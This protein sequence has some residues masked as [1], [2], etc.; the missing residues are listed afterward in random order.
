M[1]RSRAVPV[2]EELSQTVTRDEPQASQN[3]QCVQ[4]PM[5]HTALNPSPVY[6][7]YHMKLMEIMITDLA[8]KGTLGFKCQNPEETMDVV[9]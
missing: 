9:G 5:L 7:V 8:R 2:K 4:S 3:Q 6:R 1:R